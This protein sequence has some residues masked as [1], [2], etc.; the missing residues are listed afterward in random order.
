MRTRAVALVAVL[1]V[2]VPATAYAD[3]PRPVQWPEVKDQG[4]SGGSDP[5]P[6]AWPEP[7]QL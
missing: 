1:L 3:D 5:R 6:L 2:L 7:A 4:G